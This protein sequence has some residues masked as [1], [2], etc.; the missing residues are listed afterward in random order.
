[1]IYA[2]NIS[3]KQETESAL[4]MAMVSDWP[5]PPPMSY[6]A[7]DGLKI[8]LHRTNKDAW[9]QTMH[10]VAAWIKPVILVWDEHSSN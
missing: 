4:E 7:L 10:Q 6:S 2:I 9:K 3:M 8:W 5:V 1:M